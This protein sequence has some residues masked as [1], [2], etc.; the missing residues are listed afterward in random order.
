MMSAQ[1]KNIPGIVGYL[2]ILLIFVG[3]IAPAL[4]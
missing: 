2:S 1:T 4:V 3:V